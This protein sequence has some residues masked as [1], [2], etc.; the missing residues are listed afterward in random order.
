M[1]VTFID[2]NPTRKSL[3]VAINYRM[4][5]G[6]E[7]DGSMALRY[8]GLFAFGETVTEIAHYYSGN[9]EDGRDDGWRILVSTDPTL[10][11]DVEFG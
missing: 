3:R 11:S 4:V 2:Q 7:V 9:H 8:D 10:Y 6:V 1:R 5:N